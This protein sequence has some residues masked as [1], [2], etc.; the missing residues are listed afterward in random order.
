M[1][2]DATVRTYEEIEVGMEDAFFHTITVEEGEA[3]ARLCGNWQPLHTDAAFGARTMF[4]DKIA[5]GMQVGSLISTLIGMYLPGRD[6]VC[7][8]QTLAYRLPVYY[9]ET[10]RVAG[11]VVEKRDSIRAVL[12][13]TQVYRE[14]DLVIDGTALVR[15]LS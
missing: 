8:Q 12:L 11:R 4:G 7:L 14:N 15:V 1:R 6:S 13:S 10:V 9:G 3:F 5:Y 2:H